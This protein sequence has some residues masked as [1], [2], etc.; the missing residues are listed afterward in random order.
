[1]KRFKNRKSVDVISIIFVFVVSWAIAFFHVHCLQKAEP[2]FL[3]CTTSPTH[4][5][6]H[7]SASS[8]TYTL[9]YAQRGPKLP[10][11]PNKTTNTT[12]NHAFTINT[13]KL[14]SKP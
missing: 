14:N 12:H 2:C 4:S 13:S 7:N 1:M 10:I 3:S 6:M 5:N 9:V 11:N 8:L